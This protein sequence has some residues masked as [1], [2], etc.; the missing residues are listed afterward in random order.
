MNWHREL[1]QVYK[2]P[3]ALDRRRGPHV[4]PTVSPVELA[5][6]R[7]TII[8]NKNKSLSA[9]AD[10]SLVRVSSLL[11]KMV[12]FPLETRCGALWR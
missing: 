9:M 8:T 7:T 2:D 4:P 3:L 10:V 11:S 1:L 6:C 5:T 12:S